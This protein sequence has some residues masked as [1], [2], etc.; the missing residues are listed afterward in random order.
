MLFVTGE[1]EMEKAKGKL[2]LNLFPITN[3]GKATSCMLEI[4]RHVSLSCCDVPAC[5][6][7][8]HVN[9]C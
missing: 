6:D 8:Q 4:R 5:G 3:S 2:E 9:P 1:M 7:Y